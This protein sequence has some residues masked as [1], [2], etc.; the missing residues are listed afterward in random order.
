MSGIYPVYR[1]CH[2]QLKEN[3]NSLPGFILNMSNKGKHELQPEMVAKTLNLPLLANIPY[4]KKIKKALYKQAPSFHL[5]PRT[6]SSKQY[7]VLAKQLV[8]Q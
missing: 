3:H 4:D 8:P 2:K 1:V 7:L 6:K 5:Y